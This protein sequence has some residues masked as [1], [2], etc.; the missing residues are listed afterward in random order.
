MTYALSR[1]A[2]PGDWLFNFDGQLHDY[3]RTVPLTETVDLWQATP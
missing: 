2:R 3:R 1:L